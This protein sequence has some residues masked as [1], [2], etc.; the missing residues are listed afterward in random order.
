MANAISSAI[1]NLSAA[2]KSA[3]VAAASEIYRHG[4]VAADRVIF[5]WWKNSELSELLLSPKPIV[6]VG[7]AVRRETF[8]SIRAANGQPALADVPQEQDAE[9]FELHFAD[10]VELDVLTNKEPAGQGAI[11]RFLAKFGE[12]VQQVEFRCLNVDRAMA[13]VRECFS[14]APVYPKARPGAN[15]SKVN[16]VLV[17]VPGAIA[18]NAKVLIELYELPK[19]VV[20]SP[21]C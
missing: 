8:E 17:P 10:D 4:R 5:P 15:G 12:G 6:T 21:L 3:R 1:T 11:A 18:E 9:E 13:I 16:F 19:T 2:E 14:V 7:V 20:H